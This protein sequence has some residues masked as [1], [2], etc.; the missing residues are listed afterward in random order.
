MPMDY[1]R[2][3]EKADFPLRVEDAHDI[4][5]VMVLK[6]AGFVEADMEEMPSSDPAERCEVAVVRRITPLG[7]AALERLDRGGCPP[8]GP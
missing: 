5:N 8:T 3:I 6:A 4:N 2:K 1:L 7:R